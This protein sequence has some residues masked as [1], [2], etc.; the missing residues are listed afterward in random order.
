[1]IDDSPGR[2]CA[3]CCE[4]CCCPYVATL[5][6]RDLIM[7]HYEIDYDKCDE[8]IITFVICLDC[9]CSILAIIDDSFRDLKDLVDLLLAIIMS[10]S[11]AQQESTLDVVTGDPT[12]LGGNFVGEGAKQ[13]S[14]NNQDT[15]GQQP[16]Y[17]ANYGQPNQPQPN[18][19][20]PQYGQPV[21]YSAAPAQGYGHAAPAQGYGQAQPYG[22]PQNGVGFA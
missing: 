19:G 9:L 2:E 3:M 1:M 16:S 4:S 12:M 11:L 13:V 5:T 14:D 22:A 17:P 20:Q 10:C 6:N 21:A 15:Y 7:Q 18:Y 8:F